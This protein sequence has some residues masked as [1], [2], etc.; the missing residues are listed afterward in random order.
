NRVTL[1]TGIHVDSLVFTHNRIRSGPINFNLSGHIRF[2]GNELVSNDA[3]GAL[4]VVNAFSTLIR[5]NKI[6][7]NGGGAI[8]TRKSAGQVWIDSNWVASKNA[9]II[10]DGSPGMKVTNNQLIALS[11]GDTQRTLDRKSTRLNSSHVKISYAVFDLP[12]AHAFPTR[13]SSDLYKK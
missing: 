9:C 5:N 10:D 13:R 12:D 1:P 4:L 7:S 3:L 6:Q 11:G 2:E 8:T